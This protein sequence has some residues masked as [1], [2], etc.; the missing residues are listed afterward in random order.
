MVVIIT[1]NNIIVF[2]KQPSAERFLANLFFTSNF[3]SFQ[4]IRSKKRSENFW[5]VHK[6]KPP[7]AKSYFSK[8]AGFYRSC[9]LKCSVKNGILRKIFAKFTEKTPVSETLFWLRDVKM[10]HQHRCLPV[11]ITKFLTTSLLQ[12]TSGRLL[13]LL[14]FPCNFKKVGHCQQCFKNLR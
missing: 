7:V 4:K 1:V 12:N 2:T 14:V 10:R 9:H 13:L 11:N 5:K 6:K 3:V 8:V